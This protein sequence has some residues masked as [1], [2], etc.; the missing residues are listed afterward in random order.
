M[1]VSMRTI[2]A[3]TGAL[4]LAHGPFASAAE[5]RVQATAQ[6]S[7]I[8]QPRRLA[9]GE[10]VELAVRNAP[11]VQA[12]AQG[13]TASE[14]R[15]D[16]ARSRR[17][18][19]LHVE[20]NVLLW[21]KPLDVAFMVPGMATGM[22]A[23]AFR[24]RDQRTD[25]L[26]VTLAQPISG[27]LVL[28][29]LVALEQNGADAAH[30]DREGA[31]LDAGQRAAEAYLRLLSA[32]ALH[33]VATRGLSQVEAQLERAKLLEKAG[34]LGQVDVLRL[35]SARE[36]ARQGVLRAQA[37]VSVA[38]SALALAVALPRGSAVD[39]ADDL[40]DPPPP[41]TLTAPEAGKLAAEGRPELQAARM[42]AEQAERGQD[43]A[44]AQ[45]Y[46]NVN[47]VGTYQRN[48]G[49]AFTPP[50]AWFVGA[51]LSW[52]VWDWGKAR[53]D[54]REAGAKARQAS[55]GADALADQI[56]FDAQRRLTDARTAYE[57]LDVA[58]AAQVA[59]EEAYRIQSVR[60]AQGAAT[61][62]DVLD[63]ETDVSR[64][65]SNYAQ[66]RYDYYLAQASLARAIGR[67]PSTQPG[68]SNA[69]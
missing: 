64:A 62:T 4:V 58:R 56:A 66:A 25:Q 46:P 28:S 37:G 33:G 52:D 51:T 8:A 38:S 23:P 48:D 32:K 45:M 50:N 41:L 49:Q 14:E 30:A 15:V 6:A 27:L 18:P 69:P 13:V 20:G 1:T 42:R 19:G 65:R 40:P 9:F 53:A 63:A 44:R 10:A 12:S 3:L 47:A 16:S 7:T 11:D 24:A 60:Y 43:V 2:V 55:I 21:N 54:V 5:E 57:T 26:T 31:R 68:G 67:L 39:A 17:Y 59:A 36:G 22:P 34:V 29:R 61:T 35:T